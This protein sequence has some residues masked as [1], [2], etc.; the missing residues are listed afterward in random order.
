MFVE[1][2]ATEMVYSIKDEQRALLQC[3]L[4]AFYR[5][6]S[7]AKLRDDAKFEKIGDIRRCL[8][9]I[10]IIFFNAVMGCPKQQW[11]EC[12]EEQI[13]FFKEADLPF[14]WYVDENEN[15]AF[16]ERL[17]AYGFQDPGICRG[18]IGPLEQNYLFEMPEGCTIERVNSEEDME[19]FN[20]LVCMVFRGIQGEGKQLYKKA[21]WTA[22][23]SEQNKMCH[24]MLRKNGRVI[25]VLSTIIEGE[26]ISFWN[27]ATLPQFRSRGFNTALRRFVIQDA[28]AKGCRF[29]SSYL[30]SESSKLGFDTKYRFH[31]FFIPSR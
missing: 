17:L 12:I 26:G 5:L 16:K 27:R 30:M 13:Q 18:V 31:A 8:S 4:N 1:P 19:E 7:D 2:P 6:L 24:W 23:R 28:R 21:L 3:H 11:D 29:G 10:P 14:V 20:D 9:G 25:S 15:P 22:V